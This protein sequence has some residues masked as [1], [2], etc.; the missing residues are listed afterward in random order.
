MRSGA[1]VAL[2]L[3]GRRDLAIGLIGV[4]LCHDVLIPRTL[5]RTRRRLG[6]AGLAAVLAAH[7][8]FA[9]EVVFAGHHGSMHSPG[10]GSQLP[11]SVVRL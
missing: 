6:L 10:N 8:G 5:A 1:G 7:I 3:F 2:F 11:P 9:F 4:A